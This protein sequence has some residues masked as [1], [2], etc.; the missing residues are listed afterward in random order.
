MED[1]YIVNTKFRGES[2]LKAMKNSAEIIEEVL[3]NNLSLDAE[4]CASLTKEI[5]FQFTENGISYRKSRLKRIKNKKGGRK[6]KAERD[7]YIEKKYTNIETVGKA[8]AVTI[9]NYKKMYIPI[10]QCRL[11]DSTGRH[12][13]IYIKNWFWEK[14]IIELKK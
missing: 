10:S 7:A 8:Y 11:G 9:L 1:I 2:N 6:T 3:F 13:K 12:K 5:L 4:E 14:K